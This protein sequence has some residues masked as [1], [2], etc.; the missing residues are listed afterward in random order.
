SVRHI[1]PEVDLTTAIAEVA[2]HRSVIGVQGNNATVGGRNEELGSALRGL[3][4]FS[5]H[6][7]IQSRQSFVWLRL[8]TLGRLGRGSASLYL[9]R[10]LRSPALGGLCGILRFSPCLSILRRRYTLGVIVGQPAT[11]QMLQRQ[12]IPDLR[13]ITPDF[14]ARRC[15]QCNDGL[16]R[17]AKIQALADL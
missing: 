10:L 9:G 6:R 16:V 2:A 3:P 15:V 1:G 14:L 7:Q 8:R 5:G 11:S 4:I 13:V 12:L 17:C